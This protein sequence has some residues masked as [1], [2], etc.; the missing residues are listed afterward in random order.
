LK[1]LVDEDLPPKVAEVGH[2]LGLDVLSVHEIE[3]RGYPDDEQLRF[4]A[5]EERIFLT[6]NRNDFLLLS[7]EFYR[8]G[9][10]YS[11]VLIVGRTL[12]N[13]HPERVA[14]ALKRWVDARTEAAE[15]FG[16]VDFL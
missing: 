2:N 1:F 4:A 11:G 3:R 5:G 12:P 6:R 15:G 16:G 8:V 14:H 9:E 13:N 7:V 10:P